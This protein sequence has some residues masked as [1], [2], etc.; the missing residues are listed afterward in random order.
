MI[1]FPHYGTAR[2]SRESI[3]TV[4]V[5]ETLVNETAV[6]FTYTQKALSSKTAEMVA[7]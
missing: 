6:A 7:L 2:L 5:L 3:N 1:A 4:A